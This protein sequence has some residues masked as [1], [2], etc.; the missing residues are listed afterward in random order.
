MLLVGC[1]A[2]KIVNLNGGQG[3]DGIVKGWCY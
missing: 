3:S 2:A 1:G